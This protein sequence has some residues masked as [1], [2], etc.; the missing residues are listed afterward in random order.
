MGL[1]LFIVFGLFIGFIARALLPGRQKMGLLGTT[2]IGMVG[3]LL[4]GFLGSLISNTEP[5]R[6]HAAGFIGSIVG[7][8]LLLAIV[9]MGRRH[10]TV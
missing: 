1:L 10:A 4:G 5:T 3:S 7:A 6:I 8:I 2:L 9:Q